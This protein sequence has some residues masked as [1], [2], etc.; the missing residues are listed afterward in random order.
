VP[1]VT[2]EQLFNGLAADPV[3][4]EELGG[5]SVTADGDRLA[6]IADKSE[7]GAIQTFV[8]ELGASWSKATVNYGHLESSRTDSSTMP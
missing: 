2:V 3:L 1:G 6:L 4:R 7:L 8:G 5:G